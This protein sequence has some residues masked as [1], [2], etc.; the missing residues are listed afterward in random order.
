M[1]KLVGLQRRLIGSGAR[2]SVAQ[3]ASGA[4]S[5]QL[6]ALL[7][8]PVISRLYGPESFGSL[9]VVLSVSGILSE[10]VSLRLELAIPNSTDASRARSIAKI[11]LCVSALMTSALAVLMWIPHA[12]DISQALSPQYLPWTLAASLLSATFNI[13]SQLFI[14]RGRFA[15]LGMRSFWQGLVGTLSSIGL[16]LAGFLT[17]GLI[18]SQALGRIAAIAM[19][20]GA[21]RH[22]GSES[23][24]RRRIRWR[25][26]W[27]YPVLFTPAGILNTLG[28]QLPLLLTAAWFG[29]QAAGLLG[30]AQRVLMLPASVVGLAI[31][32]VYLGRLAEVRR[33]GKPDQR[34]AATRALK[35]LVPIGVAITL[36]AFALAPLIGWILGSEWTDVSQ[37]I[38]ASALVYGTSFIAAPLQMVLVA[39]AK[40]GINLLLDG[41]RVVLVVTAAA[42]A[43]QAGLSAVGTV[44]A[45][46]IAQAF[47]YGITIAAA[48]WS[49][50]QWDR[51]QTQRI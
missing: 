34:M 25:T 32:Q 17:Y 11:A 15:T 40:G 46:S 24:A 26:L 29:I 20:G 3:V 18:L 37:F 44:A 9:A 43:R 27:K 39:N 50:V 48:W 38:Q 8:L 31:G 30:V 35:A 33:S 45:M 21:I 5:G 49:T 7:A 1:R 10:V 4:L 28:G 22:D 12:Q 16:G 42:T 23:P 51:A 47:N 36:G 13:L 19:M 2:K 14:W 41:S 6:M